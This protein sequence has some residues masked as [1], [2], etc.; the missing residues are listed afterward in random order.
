MDFYLYE[1]PYVRTLNL[2]NLIQSFYI[3]TFV[4]LSCFN[5]RLVVI[6]TGKFK[7]E[8]CMYVENYMNFIYIRIFLNFDDKANGELNGKIDVKIAI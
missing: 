2:K 5:D 3:Y 4:E 8:I 1:L 6:W 7:Y